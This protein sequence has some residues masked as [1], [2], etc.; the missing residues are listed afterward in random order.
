MSTHDATGTA[1]I[2]E[3]LR[4]ALAARAALVQTEDLAPVVPVVALRPR[5]QSPWVLLA[6]AAV[7]LLVLGAVHQAVGGGQRSDRVAPDPDPEVVLPLDVG[8]DW[9]AD[10]LS[11]PARLDLDG[12][13]RNEKVVFLAE[14]SEDSDG[15]TRVQTTLTGTGEEVFGIVQLDTTIGTSALEPVDADRD[16]DQELVLHVSDDD[17]VNG[18][19]PLVLDLREGHLLQA[20]VEDADLLRR[21]EHREPGSATEHYEM[22]RA[23]DYWIEDGTLFSSRSRSAFASAGMTTVRPSTYVVDRWSWTLDDAGVLR[24]AQGCGTVDMFGE[25]GAC[26]PGEVD[27]PPQVADVATGAFGVGEQA[28]YGDAGPVFTARL[29]PGD[30]PSLVIEGVGPTRSVLLDVPDPRVSLT[31]PQAIFS[32]GASVVVTSASDPG[33]VRVFTHD[34]ERLRV[35]EPVGEVEPTD[36]ESHRT[37]LTTDGSLVTAVAA[38]DGTWRVWYWL[39]ESR[40]EMTA[41]PGGVVCL[42]DAEDPATAR[43][44]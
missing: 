4:A 12:D 36:D 1:E 42:D 26:E 40:T 30:R 9:T 3:R 38:G 16:G 22:V 14:E 13:G 33:L 21:G 20:A 7:V 25:R 2:E 19:H 44:C 41:L 27:A 28:D 18:G 32:D 37:W 39:M 24:P 6:T 31:Q 35:L 29:E 34:G 5:W 43:G 15:R 10:D 11:T 8:R 17:V 23:H